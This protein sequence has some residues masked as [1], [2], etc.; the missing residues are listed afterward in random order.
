MELELRSLIRDLVKQVR[1]QGSG[2]GWKL[3]TAAA[4]PGSNLPRAPPWTDPNKVQ[5]PK[6]E[7]EMCFASQGS[8]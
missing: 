2:K 6:R 5:L 7:A 3:A 1:F 8:T 4:P